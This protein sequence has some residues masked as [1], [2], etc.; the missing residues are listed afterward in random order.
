MG[1]NKTTRG[2]QRVDTVFVLMIF[3]VF[4]VTV[5][6]VL[7]LAGSTYKNMTD[8]SRDGHDERTAL[9]YI[10]TKVKNLDSEGQITVDYFG[11]ASALCFV[12]VFGDYT[13]ETLIYLQDGWVYELFHE[14][15]FEFYPEDG[16]PIVRS[17][18][19]NFEIIDNGLIRASTDYGSLLILPRS[20]ASTEQLLMGGF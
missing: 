6:V 8:I 11:G 1:M 2:N 12:E 17:N 15:G 20:T 18:S 4:A 13:Y 5:L 9:S 7:M 10:W 14:R 19:L 16:T 3:C